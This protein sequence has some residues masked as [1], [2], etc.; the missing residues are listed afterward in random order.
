M[1]L[2]KSVVTQEQNDCCIVLSEKEKPGKLFTMVMFDFKKGFDLVDHTKLV[3]KMVQLRLRADYTKWVFSF[4]LDRRQRVKMPDG[5]V[6]EWRKITCGTPQGILLGPIAF[7]AMIN[8]AAKCT[9]NRLKYVDDLTI[10]QSCLNDSL[11]DT[12]MI[13]DYTNDIDH[14]ATRNKMVINTKKCK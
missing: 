6:S 8:D 12:S 14:W 4:L 7:L 11:D 2:T 1:S 10:Y 5:F 13:Q 3:Q 9:D